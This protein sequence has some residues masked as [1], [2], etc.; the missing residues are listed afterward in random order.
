MPDDDTEPDIDPYTH[1]LADALRDTFG[2]S[3]AERCRLGEHVPRADIP[4]V[5]PN[6]AAWHAAYAAGL[7]FADRCGFISVADRCAFA[8]GYA[9]H[10]TR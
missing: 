4:T 8:S 6:T 10:A 3:V 9:F 2:E 1:S 7:S 5:V